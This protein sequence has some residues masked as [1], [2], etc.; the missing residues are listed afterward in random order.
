[1]PAPGTPWPSA[2]LPPLQHGFTLRQRWQRGRWENR[3]TGL[4]DGCQK[5]GTWSNRRRGR[6][7]SR[8]APMQEETGTIVRSLSTEWFTPTHARTHKRMQAPANGASLW[9]GSLSHWHSRA[10]FLSLERPRLS[11]PSSPAAGRT[12]SAGRQERASALTKHA[13][14]HAHTPLLRGLKWTAGA[15]NA[16]VPDSCLGSSSNLTAG[17]R[18]APAAPA[19][20]A[21]GWCSR[22]TQPQFTF[23]ALLGCAAGVSTGHP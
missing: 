3:K 2:P 7:S 12:C 5:C 18:R 16:P 6:N 14:T 23:L 4:S 20:A 13:H 17:V 22:H 15:S 10:A 9:Q 11:V 19:T 8:G 1:M 21:E